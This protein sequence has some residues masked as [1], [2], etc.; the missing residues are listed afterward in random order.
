M[1][2]AAIL[3]QLEQLYL[4]VCKWWSWPTCLRALLRSS[5]K[6]HTCYHR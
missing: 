2:G 5:G 4:G 1:T 3:L 6:P